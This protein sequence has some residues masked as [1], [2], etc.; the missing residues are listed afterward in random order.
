MPILFSVSQGSVLGPFLYFYICF[1]LFYIYICFYI[2]DNFQIIRYADDSAIICTKK[3][4][5]N[6][7]DKNENEL[8]KIENWIKLNRLTLNYKKAIVCFLTVAPKKFFCFS[9]PPMMDYLK[10]KM[11]LSTYKKYLLITNFLGNTEH[12]SCCETKVHCERNFEHFETPC[13]TIIFEKC[14]FELRYAIAAWGGA[15]AKYLN[16]IKVQQN[17]MV[18]I[19]T[20]VSLFKTKVSPIYS[21]LNFLNLSNINELEIL[22][23]VYNFKKCA[24]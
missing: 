4:I 21:E 1:I 8:C 6:L 7:N 24:T 11:L 17:L 10:V 18:K 14:L 19:I 12:Q 16:K 15:A 20:K 2:D 22:K 13:T 3:N 9:S 23:F 5:E